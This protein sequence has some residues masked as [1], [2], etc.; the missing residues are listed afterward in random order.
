MGLSEGAGLAPVIGSSSCGQSE[1]RNAGR[2]EGSASPMTQ[3]AERARWMP[4]SGHLRLRGLESTFGSE[5]VIGLVHPCKLSDSLIEWRTRFETAQPFEQLNRTVHEP[6]GPERT[7][8]RLTRFEHLAVPATALIGLERRGWV[9]E[10]PA[11][12]GIQISTSRTCPPAPS[13]SR[14]PPAYPS[15]PPPCS[16]TNTSST[17]PSTPRHWA[18]GIP[19]TPPKYCVTSPNSRPPAHPQPRDHGHWRWH[20]PIVEPSKCQRS[21]T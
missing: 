1:A 9:R 20:L 21:R 7:T 8:M 5:E 10:E 12:A 2:T 19:S 13:P 6:T 14:S 16:P 11:D 4:G 15:A 17:C 3:L 18:A